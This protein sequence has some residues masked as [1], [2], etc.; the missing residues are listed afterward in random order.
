[1]D[2]S[3]RKLEWHDMD[4]LYDLP[5]NVQDEKV[6]NCIES[7]TGNLCVLEYLLMDKTDER[8]NFLRSY[9]LDGGWHKGLRWEGPTDPE[10]LPISDEECRALFEELERSTKTFHIVVEVDG[11]EPL[12]QDVRVANMQ[13]A[14]LRA[15][16]MLS[17]RKET[18]A[19]AVRIQEVEPSAEEA[20]D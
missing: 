9:Y 15:E 6:A 7:I 16:M 14:V 5:I 17:L 20:Q 18:R 11:E 1:M 4:C 3:T 19:V 10:M 12:T 8:S 2:A 13:A